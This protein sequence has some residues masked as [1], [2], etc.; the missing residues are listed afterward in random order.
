[1]LRKFIC[2]VCPNGCAI[3][4]ETEGKEILSLKGNLCRKGEEYV[5]GEITEPKRTISTSVLV[6]GGTLPLTSVRLTSPVEMSRVP[7]VME[8]LRKVRLTAPVKAGSVVAENILSL[9]SDVIVTKTV[10]EK[11]VGSAG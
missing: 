4:A 5:R 2:V 3:E 8:V 1:M 11:K 10:D 7:D 6:E 9:G